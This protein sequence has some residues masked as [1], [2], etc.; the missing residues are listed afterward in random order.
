MKDF[1]RQQRRSNPPLSPDGFPG[2]TPG[3]GISTCAFLSRMCIF[4][5]FA[6]RT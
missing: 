4:Y 3:R 5:L 1:R 2:S 6:C